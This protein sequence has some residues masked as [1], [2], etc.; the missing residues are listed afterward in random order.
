M[1]N[2]RISD[3]FIVAFIFS[4][5]LWIPVAMVSAGFSFP[6]PLQAFLESPYNPAAFGPTLAAVLLS[7]RYGGRDELLAL[8][9]KGVN[10]DFHR[11]WWPVILLFFPV[12]TAV[13][14]YLGVLW[15]DPQPYLYWTSQPLMVIM[16]FI[17]I[18]FLGGP[19][20]EEFGWRGYALPRL[21][22]RYS[23]IYTALIIG[24]IWG[25]WHIPLFF[26]G[27]SIQSQV[28]FWSFMILI[29]SASVI[30]TWVYNSTGSILATM[31][32]HTTGNLS[33]FLFPVQGTLAGGIFL[34]ILNVAAALAVML[35]AGSELK[36][37]FGGQGH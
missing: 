24:F 29:I 5:V 8:L 19:L 18:F 7:Y 20:Q 17:Y 10:Y 15:G 13:A 1:E 4:W 16:V 2:D 32:I 30:Y 11:L 31:I 14:L 34:M 26:I 23:P 27:G 35:F 3:F 6:Q 37:D 22:R 9:R 21:Q 25:L 28:P 33:Y 36:T 12:L